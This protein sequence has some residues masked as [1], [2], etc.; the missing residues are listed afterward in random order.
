[1]NHEFELIN[2]LYLVIQDYIDIPSDVLDEIASDDQL[3]EDFLSKGRLYKPK[4]DTALKELVTLL[5]ESA[6]QDIAEAYKDGCRLL[7]RNI[8][9]YMAHHYH[10][11]YRQ[12][13]EW[14]II[15]RHYHTVWVFLQSLADRI[16]SEAWP[17]IEAVLGDKALQ[18]AVS[19][20]IGQLE[21][22]QDRLTTND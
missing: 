20:V 18:E 5:N 15:E 8:S 21:L 14:A 10:E 3:A 4:Y 11:C 19:S 16:G 13:M 22:N 6:P 12:I 2:D 7:Q 9:G 1:M 17:I